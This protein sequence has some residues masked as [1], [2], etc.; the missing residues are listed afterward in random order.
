MATAFEK[1]RASDWKR[2]GGGRHGDLPWG[3]WLVS[4][5][6]SGQPPLIDEDGT[7]WASV[8]DAFWCGRLG[9]PDTYASDHVLDFMASYMAIMDG[10]FVPDEERVRDVFDGDHHAATLFDVVLKAAGLT[11][12]DSRRLTPEGQAVL[13]MLI[14]TRNRDNARE[15]VGLD[16]IIANR[17]IAG[18]KERQ[19]AAEQVERREQVA[20]RMMHRFATDEMDGKPA[21]KLIGLR[22]TREIPVR[23]TLWSMTWEC[24]NRYDRDRFYLWLLERIDRWDTWSEMVSR[25]GARALSEHFMKL[26]FCDRFVGAEA[27]PSGQN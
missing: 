21:V 13:L 14:A 20:A 17:T 22:I 26:A 11:E 25:E 9:F 3:Y 4:S 16:W 1:L 5:G 27:A 12:T 8:R 10:R 15:D 6:T 23:S 19:S 7:E 2:Y 18:W 24:Q